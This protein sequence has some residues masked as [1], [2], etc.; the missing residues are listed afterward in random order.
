MIAGATRVS[1]RANLLALLLA[2]GVTMKSFLQKSGGDNE[3]V[4]LDGKGVSAQT[5]VDDYFKC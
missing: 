2:V 1:S 3:V 4:S 5:D